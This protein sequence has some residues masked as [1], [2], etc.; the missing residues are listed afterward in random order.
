MK[1]HDPLWRAKVDH[2]RREA[3]RVI[4]HI[5][6][7]IVEEEDID[8]LQ[9]FVMFAL[10]LMQAEGPKKWELAKLNAEIMSLQPQPKIK[11]PNEC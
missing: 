2:T 6:Y 11:V 8:M 7:G 1:K 3:M 4:G 5:R 9:N 10:A